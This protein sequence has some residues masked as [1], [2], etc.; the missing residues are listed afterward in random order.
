MVPNTLTMDMGGESQPWMIGAGQSASDAGMLNN[1]NQHFHGSVDLFQLSD[2][3]DNYN[4]PSDRDGN[5]YGT[6]GNDLIDTSY[7]G[8]KDG[9]VIDGNDAILPGDAPN[10]D[11]V[12]LARA[13]TPCWPGL[14]TIW[15]KAA[16]LA[17]M[18]ERLW[19]PWRRQPLWRHRR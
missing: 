11:R 1:I 9:D 18:H 7:T 8:D 16:R 17:R 12:S 6:A 4:P 15:S 3:V 5:V 10:D 13:M 14:A 19:R 2:T